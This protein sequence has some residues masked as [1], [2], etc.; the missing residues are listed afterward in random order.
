MDNHFQTEWPMYSLPLHPTLSPRPTPS[1]PLIHPCFAFRFISLLPL[2][3][4]P[5]LQ[6]LES[7]ALVDELNVDRLS[8]PSPVECVSLSWSTDGQTLFAGIMWAA[9][10]ASI[11]VQTRPWFCMQIIWAGA[12]IPQTTWI[13]CKSGVVMCQSVVAN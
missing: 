6:D 3:S 13:K 2:L 11:S 10:I 8:T 9:F 12:P 4:P 5:L 1:L 7:K